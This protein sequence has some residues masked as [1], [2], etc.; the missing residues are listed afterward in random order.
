MS[1]PEARASGLWM[2]WERS[3]SEACFLGTEIFWHYADI[4]YRFEESSIFSSFISQFLHWPPLPKQMHRPLKNHSLLD[5]THP[6]CSISSILVSLR[7]Q[8]SCMQFAQA[9]R[10]QFTEI[11]TVVMDIKLKWISPDIPLHIAK[12]YY[13]NQFKKG[14]KIVGYGLGC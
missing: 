3:P 1:S 8:I 6:H 13:T 2:Q 12:R 5:F 14:W 7:I 10:R 11:H 4:D 9:R